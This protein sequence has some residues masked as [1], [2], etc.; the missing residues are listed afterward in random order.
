MCTR[1][2]IYQ[3][4]ALSLMGGC[5]V[6]IDPPAGEPTTGGAGG[7]ASGTAGTGGAVAP[8]PIG[9]P[10]SS[11]GPPSASPPTAGPRPD[12]GAPPDTGPDPF[13]LAPRCSSGTQWTGGLRESPLMQPGEPCADC[14]TRMDEG[15][16]LTIAGTIYETGHEPSQCYGADGTRGSQRPQIVVEDATG[17]MITASV[18]AAGNFYVES[19]TSVTPPLK[20]KVVFGGRERAMVLPVPTG[21]CN[22]CHT[23]NGT[24]SVMGAAKAPGRI[25]L[26]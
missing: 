12:G 13:A 1:V 25:V 5:M 6:P 2:R 16:R 14:H 23:Q 10:P 15:P 9:P 19:R 26:P 18:N 7:S 24:T 20:A 3:A 11:G 17:R 8:T 21:D 4:I 22:T